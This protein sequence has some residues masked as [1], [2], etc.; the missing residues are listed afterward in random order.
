MLNY[1]MLTPEAEAFNREAPLWDYPRP[2][3]R[4]DSYLCLN[5]VWQL[6]VTEASDP[7]PKPCGEIVVPYSPESV[8]SGF[9]G[10][11]PK[12]CVLIYT[13]TVQIPKEFL[14]DVTFLHIGAADER[15][16]V[17]VNEKPLG[18]YSAGYL[19]IRV[20]I[21]SAIHEGENTICLRVH[22]ETDPTHPIGK[23]RKKRGGIWYTPISGIWQTVWM[24]SLP[25]GYLDDLQTTPDFAHRFVEIRANRD[26]SAVVRFAGETVATAHSENGA[27]RIELAH[28]F[29]PWSPETPA[30]YDLELTAGE[31]CVSS[32]FAMR[33]FRA[34]KKTFYL[35]EK[36]YFVNGVLDQGYFSDGIYTPASYDRFRADIME[37]KAL[38]F[39]TLRKHIK[40]EPLVFYAL[41]DSIGMLVLQDM[42]NVG[43]Y[44]FFR[45]TVLPMLGKRHGKPHITGKQ[46]EKDA[47]LRHSDATL[48]HL[49]NA[50]CIVYYTIFNEGWGQF[51]ADAAY[52]RLKALDPS[53]VYDAT[54]GWFSEHRSDVIS[55]HI[56]FRPIRLKGGD[57]PIIVSEFGGYSHAPEGHRFNTRSTMGYRIY[58]TAEALEADFIRLY[59]GEILGN[60][61]NGLAGAIYTQLSD[62]EDECN[63]ILSY[64]RRVKKLSPVRI[65]PMMERIDAAFQAMHSPENK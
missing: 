61:Q 55:E 29:H 17:T 18:T 48:M 26:F 46:A 22:D 2:Q 57:R 37:M 54:S 27:C 30:L 11:L 31:D 44:S 1:S 65:K 56:Y 24:E 43:K 35:N 41:C 19:P 8:L 7:T 6:S 23:Q 28:A 49:Y 34:D 4:R 50:P 12:D 47:F 14:R 62:V 40:V 59:E 52:D 20:D 42:V 60:L 38:G 45:H 13:R 39:N 10:K 58:Q 3:C 5:G 63:G 9:S 36:P 15:C 51:D 21:S 32:Y 64:D 53:R 33:S 25:T 16:E